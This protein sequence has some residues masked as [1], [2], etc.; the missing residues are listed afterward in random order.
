MRFRR[1]LESLLCHGATHEPGCDCRELAQSYGSQLFKCDRILCSFYNQGFATS[2]ERDRHIQIHSRLYKCPELSCL[3][4]DLG[5]QTSRDLQLHIESHHT[6]I[7]N[8]TASTAMTSSITNFPIR[9]LE[10]IIRDAIERDDIDLLQNA[11]PSPALDDNHGSRLFLHAARR[12]SEKAIKLILKRFQSSEFNFSLATSRAI[13]NGNIQ[14]LR[15]CLERYEDIWMGISQPFGDAIRGGNAQVLEVFLQNQFSQVMLDYQRP[16]SILAP[17]QLGICKLQGPQLEEYMAVVQ[18]CIMPATLRQY[19][20]VCAV[21]MDL[22]QLASACLQ[23]GAEINESCRSGRKNSFQNMKPLTIAVQR[24]LA[25]MTVFLLQNGADTGVQV[26][27]LAG[28]RRIEASL[29][30]P[31]TEIVELYHQGPAEG[32]RRHA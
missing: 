6:A 7:T 9:D 30:M 20:F 22:I 15:F 29:G 27:S 12:G 13:E 32:R 16:S 5:L 25:E 19:I 26:E 24:G 11:L 23:D 31:W 1:C 8:D 3:F 2:S 18:G 21:D 17:S 4:A 28:M 14:T 10:L